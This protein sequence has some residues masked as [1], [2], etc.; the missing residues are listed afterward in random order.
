MSRLI[1]ICTIIFLGL[2]CLTI[3]AQDTGRK[4]EV[5]AKAGQESI[6]LRWGPNDPVAW[7][8]LNEYGYIV[9][10]ITISRNG[11]LLNPTENKI[12][13]ELPL[14]PKPL[15]NWEELVDANDYAAVAAQA[16]HGETFELTENYSSDIIQVVQKAQ[17]LEQRFSFALFAADQEY[18][19]AEMSGLAFVD[20]TVKKNEKYL[21]R[22]KSAVPKELELI[23]NGFVYISLDDYEELPK[24]YDVQAVFGDKSVILS[25]ER[26]NFEGIYN[27]FIV[28]KS[29]DNNKTFTSITE[30]PIVNA[31]PSEEVNT[32]RSYKLDSLSRNGK[33]VSYRVKGIN[34][35]GEISPP[36][37]TVSGFGL[38]RI[39]SAPNI[40]DWKTDNIKANIT[41]EF[42]NG[43]EIKGF[44]VER[45]RSTQGPYKEIA[46]LDN[47]VTFYEDTQ[48]L[49]TNYYRVVAYND[50]H[51]TAS[52][53]VL[54]QLE[55][56]IP[57]TQPTGLTAKIDSSGIVSLKW[58]ENEEQDLFGYRVYRS[59][60]K[61]AEFVQ[62]TNKAVPVNEW[63]DSL[64]L[65]NLTSKIYY[66]VQAVDFRYN[67]SE[68][69][70]IA[71]LLK[72]DLTPPVPPVFKS[73]KSTTIGVQLEW[74]PSSSEDVESHQLYR[75]HKNSKN[76]SL[77]EFFNDSITFHV[78]TTMALTSDY[79]YTI[80]AVDESNLESQPAKP[81]WGK[82]LDTGIRPEIEGIKVEVN[83]EQQLVRLSWDYNSNSLEKF[84]IYRAQNDEPLSLYKTIIGESQGFEDKGLTINSTYK[85]RVKAIYKDGAESKLSRELI[86]NY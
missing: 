44:V 70:E 84:V 22:V 65:D 83:R 74:I 54:V 80:V 10:R 26:Q 34:A 62:V 21:Y 82:K 8:R 76:W 3:N 42:S 59:N 61:N 14:K 20:N 37:D 58:L 75:R 69:S 68:R 86:I 29:A 36:S 78:D 60:F 33:K 81:V 16:I 40:I 48:P 73:I 49:A 38:V 63:V 72:P 79:Q 7:E 25:W 4:I 17:E 85:Y 35:F 13:T 28:E 53:P 41:W 15:N 12:L 39:S 9:E 11:I 24:I 1:K 23:N 67:P 5:L 2:F 57:P 45:T 52:F 30:N 56:S 71:E 46:R 18:E 51:Q 77:I 64:S 31:S 43:E 66:K 32:R 19:V 50:T 6:M 47:Y 27:S 55:D